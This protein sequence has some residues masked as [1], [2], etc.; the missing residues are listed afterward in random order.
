[1][2]MMACI[3]NKEEVLVRSVCPVC[4]RI[5]GVADL[6]AE[7]FDYAENGPVVGYYDGWDDAWD[8]PCD[9]CIGAAEARY[10]KEFIL[11]LHM[12]GEIEV[13][14]ALAKQCAGSFDR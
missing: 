10:G 1:M 14:E 11:K 7:Y 9:Q 8:L 4:G 3:I 5:H 13:V 6:A 12:A 2:K